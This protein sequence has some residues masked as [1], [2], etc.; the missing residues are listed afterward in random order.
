MTPVRIR[1]WS[2]HHKVKVED[3]PFHLIRQ[4][5]SFM[6]GDDVGRLVATVAAIEE[7]AGPI[8]A[9]VVDTVSRVLPGAEENLQKDM[10]LFVEACV[11]VI[12]SL[13]CVAPL[14]DV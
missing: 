12:S 13:S 2:Q 9:V 10:T 7:K 6:R 3:A 14:L 5:M 11:R 4:S 1:A 8:A